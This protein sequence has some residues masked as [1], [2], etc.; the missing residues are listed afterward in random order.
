MFKKM[1]H[2]LIKK[3]PFSKIVFERSG[4]QYGIPL[5]VFTINPDGSDCVQIRSTGLAPEWSPDGKWIAFHE[6]PE[7]YELYASNIYIMDLNGKKVKQLTQHTDGAAAC[8]TWSPDSNRIAY[9]LW[10]DQVHQIWTIDI[11]SLH[12]KQ[13]TYEG[14][15]G[16]PV[17]ILS[18]E[19]IF[20]KEDLS[21][22]KIFIMDSEG[23]NQREF[24]IFFEGDKEP[25]WSRD[26]SKI[27]FIRNGN[28]CMMNSDGTNLQTIQIKEG[29]IEVSWSP[30]AQK[31]TYSSRKRQG[32]GA[33]IYVVDIDGSNEK[34]ITESPL[35]PSGKEASSFDVCWSPW[36]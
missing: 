1:L 26:G 12:K 10:K 31:I 16:Y 13:L 14:S 25:M 17:C 28:I 15:N 9:S 30:D 20:F 5:G 6:V 35:D 22:Q 2:S 3:S 29:A 4:D 32:Y 19:I 34:R 18:N 36:L 23:Q 8:P 11:E 7:G 33:E 21:P 27:V 24:N